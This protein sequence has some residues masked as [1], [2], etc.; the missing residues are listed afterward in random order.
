METP[1][2]SVKGLVFTENDP[3]YM[4]TNPYYMILYTNHPTKEDVIFLF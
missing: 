3:Y 1:I 4:I 2:S